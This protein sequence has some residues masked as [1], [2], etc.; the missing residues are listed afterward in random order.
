[1]RT[2]NKVS[3]LFQKVNCFAGQIMTAVIEYK[4]R[5]TRRNMGMSIKNEPQIKEAGG[6]RRRF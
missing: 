5:K 1:M 4:I 3:F 2:N 6:L